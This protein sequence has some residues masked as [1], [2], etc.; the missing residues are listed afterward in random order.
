M[1]TLKNVSKRFVSGKSSTQALANINLNIK[2]GQFIA[3][4]GPS[5]SGKTTL[6]N[7]IGGLDFPS[8][9]E[10]EFNKKLINRFND[11]EISKYRNNDVGFIFQEFHLAHHLT[12]KENVLLPT[13]FNHTSKKESQA[14][15]LIEEVKLTQKSHSKASELSG[16]EKQRTAIARALIN[17]PQ[18][19]L[20]DEPTG[21]L[22]LKTGE[23]IINLLKQL[24]KIHKTTLIVATHDKKIA[25]AAGRIIKI[26]QG[27]I[28]K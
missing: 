27:K 23:T 17:N 21:N 2:K 22:D 26:H 4:V 19:I 28:S 10:I 16:G 14:E 24:H 20:A 7:I 8:K 12:V 15:K 6:L 25:Q 11:N 9:G 1:I 13:F 18:I 3:I 5:G